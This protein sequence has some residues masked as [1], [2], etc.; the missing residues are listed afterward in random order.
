MVKLLKI[1][2]RPWNKVACITLT[3]SSILFA[4]DFS[5]IHRALQRGFV[6]NIESQLTEVTQL[7][8]G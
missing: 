5:L 4:G 7:S 3:A 2:K 8:F 1:D 6:N